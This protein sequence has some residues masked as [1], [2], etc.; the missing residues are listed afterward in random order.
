MQTLKLLYASISE[1]YHIKFT[2]AFSVVLFLNVML[3]TSCCESADVFCDCHGMLLLRCHLS[4]L[5]TS[6]TVHLF[7]A[8]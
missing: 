2:M 5:N 4:S 3:I 7:E 6:V 1:S 8:C